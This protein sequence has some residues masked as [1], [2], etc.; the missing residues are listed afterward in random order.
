MKSKTSCSKNGHII[1]KTILGK[2]IT[3]FW[4]IWAVYTLFWLLVIPVNQSMYF[5]A[6]QRNLTN[7]K[8]ASLGA[9]IKADGWNL[10]LEC[11]ISPDILIV[12]SFIMAGITG[13]ALYNYLFTSKSANWFH[14]LPV[15]RGEL[16]ATNVFSGLMFM[17]IPQLITFIASILVCVSN[18]VGDVKPFAQWLLISLGVSFLFWSMVTFCAMFAGQLFAVPVYYCVVNF[19]YMFIKLVL[20]S[21]IGFMGYGIDINSAVSGLP[22]AWL[23]PVYYLLRKLGLS[24]TNIMKDGNY[25]VTGLSFTGCRVV[26]VYCIFAAVL[27]IISAF[28]Y[29]KRD[30]ESAGDLLTFKFVKPIFRWGVGACGGFGVGI[31]LAS[32]L[33]EMNLLGSKHMLIFF[34]L[35]LGIVCFFIAEMFVQK[36]F[37]VFCKKA[38]KECGFFCIFILVSYG[39]MYGYSSYIGSY[40]PNAA[41]VETASVNMD[42]EIKYSGDSIQNVIDLQTEILAN[43]DEFEAADSDN[44]SGVRISYQLKNGKRVARFYSLPTEDEGYDILKSIYEL[45]CIPDNYKQYSIGSNIKGLEGGRLSLYDENVNFVTEYTFSEEDALTVYEGIIKDIDEGRMQKY[46][47]GYSYS[48]DSDSVRQYSS[49]LSLSF[50]ISAGQQDDTV[51]YGF[52]TILGTVE[53]EMSSSA[54]SYSEYDDNRDVY[55]SFGPDCTNTIDALIAVN[56]IDSADQLYCYP[57]EW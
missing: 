52:S 53:Y 54:Y 2:N 35:A 47:L 8:D 10:K 38:W 42:Y 7:A 30:I 9:L 57:D 20:G 27:F 29:K 21:T 43:Q 22:R 37:K 51:D 18:G 4:P 32:F 28:L 13:M 3:L 12:A 25:Y 45:E 23:S 56:A 31:L 33:R 46:N 36:K 16:F 48:A 40:I 34:S 50:K 15:T 17:W 6:E 1:N 39:A 24:R 14:S 44:T 49:D 11:L 19:L 55:F 26:A 41:D 5:S